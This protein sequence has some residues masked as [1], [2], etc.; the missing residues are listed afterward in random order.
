VLFLVPVAAALLLLQKLLS[1]RAWR[2]LYFIPLL[3]LAG[4]F[5]Y[6]YMEYERTKP[7]R[8][9]GIDIDISLNQDFTSAFLE[10]VGF[11]FWLTIALSLVLFILGCISAR[12][13]D[14]VVTTDQGSPIIDGGDTVI[15][16]R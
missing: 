1:R 12:R 9:D 15:D 4:L 13:N 3:A 10:I 14:L 16:K 2:L 5:T 6:A 11:G 8:D 7:T